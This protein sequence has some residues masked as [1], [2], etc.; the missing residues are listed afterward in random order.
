M[1]APNGNGVF[2]TNMS[3]ENNKPTMNIAIARTIGAI[4]ISDVSQWASERVCVLLCACLSMHACA[5]T[6]IMF[7]R[8]PF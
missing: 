2:T 8:L 1:R 3:R 5:C 6:A 4:R 7:C